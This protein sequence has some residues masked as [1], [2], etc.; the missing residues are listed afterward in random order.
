MVP[1]DVCRRA[2]GASV[3]LWHVLK[4]LPLETVPVLHGCKRLARKVNL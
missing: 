1:S 2:A 3:T 4:P